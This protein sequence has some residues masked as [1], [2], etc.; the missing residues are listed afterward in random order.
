MFIREPAKIWWLKTKMESSRNQPVF[1]IDDKRHILGKLNQA[2][3]FENFLHTKYVGQKRFSLQGGETLIPGL[4]AI[5]QKGAE[6]GIAEFVIGMPH[7]GRLNVLANIL[8]KSYRDIFSEFEGRA[9]A[10][11]V[12]AGDVK[13]HLGYSNEVKTRHGDK[14]TLN[15][16]P[17]PSHLEAVDP[18]VL[19]TTR[20]KMDA[21]YGGDYTRVAPILIPRRRRFRRAGLRL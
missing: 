14:V 11:F 15:L 5:I 16:S 6:M 1:A 21:K 4:D 17:N 3:V 19:G 13:Y 12:F 2:V 20:A 10:D 18:V 7:R 9:F 8:N